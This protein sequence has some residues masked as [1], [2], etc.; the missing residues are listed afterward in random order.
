MIWM[1]GIPVVLFFVA[2]QLFGDPFMREGFVDYTLLCCLTVMMTG[3]GSIPLFGIAFGLGA[4]FETHPE[5]VNN[6]TL[7]SIRDKDGVTG[8]FFLGSGMIQS[9]QYYFYYFKNA[10]GSVTPGRVRAGQ[11]VRVYEEDRTTAELVEFHWEL[12]K[13]W[14]WTVA[15]PVHDDGWSWKFYVPKG[16][17]RTGYTM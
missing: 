1:L 8:Q 16:T 10:D 3:L 6:Y 11:G 9:E 4:L 15:F 2:K 14:A 17:V 12:N 7:V 13:S 5:V